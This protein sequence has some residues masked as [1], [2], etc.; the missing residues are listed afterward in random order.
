MSKFKCTVSDELTVFSG[1]FQKWR[2]EMR[3]IVINA[4]NYKKAK[5]TDAKLTLHNTG[6]MCVSKHIE[7]N[8]KNL[9]GDILNRFTTLKLC[10]ALL[11][12]EK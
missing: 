7:I 12:F 8:L 2:G 3:I 1:S 4:I 9:E 10:D 5:K 6:I 11:V